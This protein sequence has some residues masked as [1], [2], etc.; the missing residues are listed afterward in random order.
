MELRSGMMMVIVLGG[1][2]VVTLSSWLVVLVGIVLK[3]VIQIG[4]SRSVE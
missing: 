4:R 2:I 3:S 1:S